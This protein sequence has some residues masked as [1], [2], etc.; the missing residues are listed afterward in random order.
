MFDVTMV[1]KTGWWHRGFDSQNY[2]GVEGVR[3]PM[4]G[5]TIIIT[6]TTLGEWGTLWHRRHQPLGRPHG[7]VGTSTIIGGCVG[8]TRH[9]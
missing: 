7:M 4:L 5:R 9:Q 2:R 8:H 3:T 6:E 1:P